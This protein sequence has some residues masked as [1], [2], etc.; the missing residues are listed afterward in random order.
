V[1]KVDERGLLEKEE[2]RGSGKM[3][4]GKKT[5]GGRH[6]RKLARKWVRRKCV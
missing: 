6:V 2:E 4:R 5:R 1:N 3:R